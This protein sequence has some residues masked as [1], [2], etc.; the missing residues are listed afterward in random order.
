[1]RLTLRELSGAE[2]V[3]CAACWCVAPAAWH[4]G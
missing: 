1:M 2:N 4:Y 3:R